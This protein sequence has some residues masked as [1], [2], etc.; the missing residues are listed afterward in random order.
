MLW[1]LQENK[2]VDSHTR[3][4]VS[5]WMVTLLMSENSSRANGFPVVKKKIRDEILDTGAPTEYVRRSNFYMVMKVL[6]QHNLILE[7]GEQLGKSLYKIVMLKFISDQCNLFNR[8]PI[9][10]NNIELVS[11]ALA[12]VARR[13][14]KLSTQSDSLKELCERIVRNACT[15]I[16]ET[17]LNIDKQIKKMQTIDEGQSK[18]PTLKILD[19]EA[20]INQ[21]V[22]KLHKYLRKQTTETSE[23]NANDML[24]I[25]IYKRFSNE[26]CYLAQFHENSDVIQ[27]NLALSDFENQIL[28]HSN[29]ESF[30]REPKE[31][32]AICNEYIRCAATYY[33]NDPLGHSKMMLVLLKLLAKLDKI[34]TTSN[35]LLLEHRSGINPNIIDSLL[36]PQLVDMEIAHELQTYFNER[37]KVA[38]LPSL[39]EEATVSAG[40]FPARLG[41]R[42]K[43]IQAFLSYIGEIDEQNETTTFHAWEEG[44]KNVEI[45]RNAKSNLK[46]EFDTVLREETIHD[47][48]CELCS[49]KKTIENKKN[50]NENVQDLKKRVSKLSHEY[51]T[52]VHEEQE[53]SKRCKL[54]SLNWKIRSSKIPVYERLLPKEKHEQNAI[55]VELNVPAEVACLR[56]ALHSFYKYVTDR[57]GEPVTVLGC[58]PKLMYFLNRFA[59]NNNNVKDKDSKDGW[60]I[61]N[62]SKNNNAKDGIQL[63]NTKPSAGE[64]MLHVDQD[65][66]NFVMDNECGYIYHSSSY[67]IVND[68]TSNIIKSRCTLSVERFSKYEGMNRFLTGTTHTQNGVLAS[69]SECSH[70]LSLVEFKNFGSLRA[71]GHRLQWRKLYTMIEAETL[72]FENPSVLSLIMQTIWEAGAGGEPGIIRESHEDLQCL[73]FTR[74]LIQLLDKYVEQQKNN[75][76]HPLKLL[77]VVLVA[78]RIFEVNENESLIHDIAVILDKSRSIAMNW[79]EIN[80]KAIQAN[81][82]ADQSNQ[83]KLRKNLVFIAIAGAVTF[84][85]HPKHKFFGKIFSPNSINGFSAYRM[86]LLFTVTLNNNRILKKQRI[87]KEQNVRMLLRLVRNIGIHIEPTLKMLMKRDPNDLYHFVQ[88]MWTRSKVANF[89]DYKFHAECSQ[90]LEISASIKKRSRTSVNYVTIDLITGSFLVNFL[91]VSRLP[92]EIT[93]TDLFNRTFEDFVFEVQP[94][95]SRSFSSVH[96]FNGKSY[97][98]TLAIDNIIIVE[99]NKD[100]NEC[101]LVP[102]EVLIN[103]IPPLLIEKYSHWFN[104]HDKHIE[105]RPKLFSDAKFSTQVSYR[106]N[107]K[108][109][110]LIHTKTKRYLL[111]ITSKSYKIIVG[112]LSRLE[113]QKFI[114]V[115][116]DEPKVARIE[117]VRMQLKF[118][119]DCKTDRKEGYDVLSNEFSNMRVSNQQKCGTLYGLKRGLILEEAGTNLPGKKLLLLPNGRV[120]TKL[121]GN[122]S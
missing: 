65:F 2:L 72:T 16:H 25:K 36:L 119:I 111:D 110:R 66:E 81:K 121:K 95:S 14:E 73:K 86:W 98:F 103:E 13:I 8:R 76:A 106:L 12:K 53:H 107:L 24:N 118:K 33:K 79:I 117:L 85:I 47:T 26:R 19:F 78:V 94:N 1:Y 87:E 75:W 46:H 30:E 18:F 82:K 102:S 84:H 114:H 61:L 71:D 60:H 122:D 5:K 44:R 89:L 88:S 48:K 105:F 31:L 56:D 29:L 22:E 3:D 70:D 7:L 113:Q 112:S 35:P 92:E 77:M 64:I 32:R 63:G 21:K 59:S 28:Y 93:Q 10:C 23:N 62:F 6:L 69:Q 99:R 50:M 20:D 49:L 41:S 39:I 54:C 4:Y 100:G 42:N 17:R 109:N 57:G 96:E 116:M 120:D 90:I 115:L 104:K 67:T 83:I 37:N 55:I 40:S 101:R 27:L 9:E 43:Q 45:W 97:E 74:A 34:A 51:K 38:W 80:Q 52:V 58:W 15:V 91:P 108:T 68:M 11:Q